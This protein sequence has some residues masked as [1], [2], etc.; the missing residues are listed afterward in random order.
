MF[1]RFKEI[2]SLSGM[3]RKDP[4]TIIEKWPM[5][6]KKQPTEAGAK[7]EFQLLFESAHGGM[8][9]YVEWKWSN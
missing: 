9:R 4:H 5:R 3:V 8:E 1:L 2:E 7:E 6:L